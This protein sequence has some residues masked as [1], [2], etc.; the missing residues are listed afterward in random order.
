[1]SIR[2]IVGLGNPG[3]S[4]ANTRHNA[5]FWLIDALTEP[6]ATHL[7]LEKKF[8]GV[9]GS[10]TYHTDRCF[11]LQPHTYMNESGLSIAKFIHFYKIRTE[12]I[13][14]VHDE[15][16]FPPGKTYLKFD[17]GHG[18]HNGVRNVIQHI[19][20]SF[21]RL[22]IGIG[23]PRHRD[24]VHDYVLSSP[25]ISQKK[26]IM[27]SIDQIVSVIPLLLTGHFQ[28]I[29]CELHTHHSSS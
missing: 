1:M 4:Y 7:K 27:H 3:A 29:M 16:D 19:G 2:L 22:R 20:S 12:Q 9:S 24:L 21:W 17:G 26:H 5:G 10:F 15:L 11:L 25:T 8:Q 13:L 14:V 6:Y 28:Q 23:H 18:G